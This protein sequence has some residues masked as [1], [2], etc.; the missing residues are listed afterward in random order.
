MIGV[1]MSK[2]LTQ[3]QFAKKIKV[4]PARV[5]HLVKSGIIRLIAGKINP[6]QALD[7]ISKA[8]HPAYEK[9]P[10]GRPVSDNSNAGRYAA[11]VDL[12][13]AKAKMAWLQ[14]E[15]KRGKLIDAELARNEFGKVIMNI[16]ARLEGFPNKIGP[17]LVEQDLPTII[18]TLQE[19]IDQLRHEWADPSTYRKKPAAKAAITKSK[20][21]KKGK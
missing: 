14:Y 2:L 9:N 19:S 3:A 11:Q 10:L 20:S 17:L 8:G 7:A 16:V 13:L 12:T 6:E 18:T 4:S 5:N 21:K 1:N 15:Q